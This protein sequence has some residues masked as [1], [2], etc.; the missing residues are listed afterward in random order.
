[1]FEKIKTTFAAFIA[2]ALLSVLV[3][4]LIVGMGD[5]HEDILTLYLKVLPG[6]YGFL[7][8][9]YSGSQKRIEILH[10]NTFLTWF[11]FFTGAI[12]SLLFWEYYSALGLFSGWFI[13]SLVLGQ[14]MVQSEGSKRKTET[15]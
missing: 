12:F 8:G 7:L 15:T 2:S 14:S 6:T 13:G 1:M 5:N 3:T 4:L 10:K 9:L 11:I